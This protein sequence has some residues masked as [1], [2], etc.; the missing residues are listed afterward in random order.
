MDKVWTIKSI[1][2]ENARE[3]K[4]KLKDSSG[5]EGNEEVTVE[6]YYK[7]RY[8]ITL[9]HPLLPLVETTKRGVVYPM[10]FC[11]LAKGQRYPY[12]LNEDQ[13]AS[14][15]K[16]AVERPAGRKASIDAG[17]KLLNWPADKYLQN[18]DVQIEPKQ[19]T[20]NAHVLEPPTILFGKGQKA[21]PSFSGRWDL[22][23]K[24]FLLPNTAP[25][26][27]W[28]VCVFPGRNSPDKPIVDNF[29]KSFIQSYKGH[30]GNVGNANPFTMR[31][32]GD[33]AQA[34]ESLFMGTGNAFKMRPQMF[35]FI[36]P[37]KTADT[38]FRIKKS[39]DCR[40]GIVSQCMQGAHVQKNNAQYHSNVCMKFNAKLGGTTSKTIV[41]GAK[42]P[43]SGHFTKPTMVIGADVSHAAPG[44]SNPS[45]AAMTM[46]IDRYASRYAA[47]CQTNS[48]RVEMIT[49]HNID[50]M[51][52][53]LFNHWSQNVGGGRLP[54]HV[55]YFRDGVSA[56]QYGN[57]MTY[58]VAALKALLYRLSAAN[59]DYKVRHLRSLN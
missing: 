55:Y 40:Y 12:K 37:D 30:G 20:T 22:R 2:P 15:I 24:Q 10:E 42:D 5:K 19:L 27:S 47:A 53:P 11:F 29:I 4:F 33:I 8:N 34:V 28:G 50:D 44:A 59:K 16:F 45:M 6:Q 13:T 41:K 54:A 35:V 51:M 32:T 3:Y 21:N 46:S 1:L 9:M 18:Y 17:L 38:Y 52:T 23:N 48:H 14:M 56:A 7:K 43:M 57:V 39:C 49:T 36:L 26:V 25:L 58:E 31:A